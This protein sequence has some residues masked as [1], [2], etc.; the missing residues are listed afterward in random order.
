MGRVNHHSPGPA[1]TPSKLSLSLSDCPVNEEHP[2]IKTGLE[3]LQQASFRT[4]DYTYWMDCASLLLV[5]LAFHIVSFML[6]RRYINRSGY[7]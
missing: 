4:A 2:C 7:Y 1:K 3:V 6:V 5:A